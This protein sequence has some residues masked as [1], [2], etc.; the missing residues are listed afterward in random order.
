MSDKK[1]TY[2]LTVKQQRF[3]EEYMIDFN[4]TQAAIRAGYSKR[5]AASIGDENLRK[6]AIAAM[7]DDKLHEAA[8]NSGVTVDFVL[9]TYL[10]IIKLGM[11][12]EE[13]T[14][15]IVDREGNVYNTEVKELNLPAANKA[16]DSLAKYLKMYNEDDEAG[17]SK[18]EEGVR[19]TI[20]LPDNGR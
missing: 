6:P 8:L 19:V 3:I 7:I 12:Q 13:F 2:K 10:K 14:R 17:K 9:K 20:V 5:T 4:A 15:S 18:H 16:V 1:K 11:A